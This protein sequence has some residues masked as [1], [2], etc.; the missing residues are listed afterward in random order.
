M[1]RS[2]LRYP[3][4]KIAGNSDK[5][6]RAAA[7]RALRRKN[8]ARLARGEEPLLMREVSDTWTFASDGLAQY[9]RSLDLNSY[10][11]VVTSVLRAYINSGVAKME[12]RP[13]F[14]GGGYWSIDGLLEKHKNPES[15]TDKQ[16]AEWCAAEVKKNANR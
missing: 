10:I 11:M 12:R 8:R 9:C 16:I 5:E 3:A 6:S 1:S 13:L 14:F 2:T 15:I 4:A 7:N